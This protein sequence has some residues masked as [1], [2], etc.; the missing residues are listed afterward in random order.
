MIYYVVTREARGT[1]HLFLAGD[2][3]ALAP[4]TRVIL[5]E[6]LF[7]MRRVPT[8]TWIFSD[9]ERLDREDLERAARCWAALEATDPAMKLFNHPLR[10]K[11]RYELL[12]ALEIAGIN[13][14]AVH[15]IDEGRVPERFP[16]FLRVENDHRGPGTDLLHTAEELAHAIAALEADGKSRDHRLITEYC[17]EADSE[18]R[19]RKYGAFLLDGEILPRHLL[20]N[21]HW[22]AKGR[23]REAC[24]ETIPEQI[25]YNEKNPHAEEL[26]RAFEIAGIDYGRVDYTI[27]GGRIQI[28]EINTN[29]QITVPG[30]GGGDPRRTR[31]KIEFAESFVERVLP[32]ADTGKKASVPVRF[33]TGSALQ[34]RGFAAADAI[35]RIANAVGLGRFEPVIFTRMKKA[36]RRFR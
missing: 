21:K 20:V 26:L 7:R 36:F 12:R 32:W 15:R 10:V 8:G 11:R 29:P 24:N 28:Y 1:I 4:H 23:D 33:E 13:D 14:Y 17:A 5:Y 9:L 35:R 16:V 30:W 2:G 3:K 25:E 31:I 22:V 19:F 6:E 34:R 27:V 18:G